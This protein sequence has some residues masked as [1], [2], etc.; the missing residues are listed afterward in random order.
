[1]DEAH[2][3]ELERLALDEATSGRAKLAKIEALRLLERIGRVAAADYPRDGVTRRFHPSRDSGWWELDAC[4]PGRGPRGVAGG[5]VPLSR[6][7]S[8]FTRKQK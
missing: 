1:M 5:P 2:R 6:A 8:A 7:A 3:R 4:D